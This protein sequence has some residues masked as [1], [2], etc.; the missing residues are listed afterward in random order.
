[1]SRIPNDVSTGLRGSERVRAQPRRLVAGGRPP[2]ELSL[3]YSR[4]KTVNLRLSAP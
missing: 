3:S 2:Q 1:M 4:A